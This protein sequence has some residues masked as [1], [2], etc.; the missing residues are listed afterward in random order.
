MWFATAAQTLFGLSGGKRVAA[1]PALFIQD[2]LHLIS[3]PLGS[4]DGV[5]EWMLEELCIAG[6]GGRAPA[7]IAS[8]ATTRNFEGQIEGLYDRSSRLVP[9]PG[10]DMPMKSVTLWPRRKMLMM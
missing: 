8:T 5:F 4:I 7:Y 3:G 10:L 9:P 6:E 1:P 2:E